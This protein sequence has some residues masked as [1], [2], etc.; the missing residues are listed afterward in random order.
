MREYTYNIFGEVSGD[1]FWYKIY[2]ENSE[3]IFK[4]ETYKSTWECNGYLKAMIAAVFKIKAIEEDRDNGNEPEICC[5]FNCDCTPIG[6]G[7]GS[8]LLLTAT[9]EDSLIE[10]FNPL[11]EQL[12]KQLPKQ[13]LEQSKSEFWDELWRQF[14]QLEKEEKKKKKKEEVMK[15]GKKK[16]I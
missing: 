9:D 7:V 15:Q 4:S 13:F 10:I 3:V 1:A 14:R 12:Y 8:N 11:R 16:G 6:D 5:D 2:N